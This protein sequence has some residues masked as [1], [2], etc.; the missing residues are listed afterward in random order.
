MP[1]C[2]GRHPPRRVHEREPV[3]VDSTERRRRR[4]DLHSQRLTS[5][6]RDRSLRSQVLIERLGLQPHPERGFFVETYR[7]ATAVHSSLHRGARSASTAIY[8]LVTADAP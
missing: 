5:R 3:T 4:E 2:L 8:F 1:S 6:M 7:A